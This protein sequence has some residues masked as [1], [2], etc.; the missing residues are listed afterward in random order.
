MASKEYNT[1]DI[2]GTYK[3]MMAEQVTFSHIFYYKL[4]LFDIFIRH[5]SRT[6]F[7]SLQAT[8]QFK[9]VF[10]CAYPCSNKKFWVIKLQYMIM[11]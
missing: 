4:S 9:L 3:Y 7:L 11:L 6:T 5:D 2:G 8:A 1:L 10:Y